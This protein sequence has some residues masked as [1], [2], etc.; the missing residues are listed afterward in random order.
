[1]EKKKKPSSLLILMLLAYILF[2]IKLILLKEIMWLGVL[3]YYLLKFV[4]HPCRYSSFNFS[5]CKNY[6]CN[7]HY[8][9]FWFLLLTRIK[10]IICKNYCII[11]CKNTKTIPKKKKLLYSM[12]MDEIAWTRKIYSCK[13]W[14]KIN[15]FCRDI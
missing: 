5:L 7:I 4:L 6:L 11:I 3:Y 2:N 13:N 9:L 15:I 14:I 8:H 1:M 12:G 10:K